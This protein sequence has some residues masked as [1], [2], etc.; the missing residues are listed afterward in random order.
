MQQAC[1]FFRSLLLWAP[2]TKAAQE[3]SKSW[4][5]VLLSAIRFGLWSL[6]VITAVWLPDRSGLCLVAMGMCQSLQKSMQMP[7]Q[8]QTMAE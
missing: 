3:D 1:M 6:N 7:L 5:P 2:G 4:F 8:N